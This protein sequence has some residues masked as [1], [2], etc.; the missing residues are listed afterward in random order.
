MKNNRRQTQPRWNW[1]KRCQ[2]LAKQILQELK[3]ARIIT[4]QINNPLLLNLSYIRYI[5]YTYINLKAPCSNENHT[6]CYLIIFQSLS[7]KPRISDASPEK[8]DS[9]KTRRN[10]DTRGE[11]KNTDVSLLSISFRSLEDSC[12]TWKRVNS[13]QI[14]NLLQ[15]YNAT[16][17]KFGNYSNCPIQIIGL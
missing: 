13:L 16:I 9:R 5:Q 15:T 10:W 6:A 3:T 7:L 4:T 17:F 14:V 2:K 11:R 12:S 8:A 1:G